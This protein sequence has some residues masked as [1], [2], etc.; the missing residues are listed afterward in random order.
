M[1]EPPNGDG[2]DGD[3]PDG[4]GQTAEEQAADNEPSTVLAKGHLHP[5]I[6][7]LRLI[8]ALRQ[9]A[10]PVILGIV[11]NPWFLVAALALFVAAARATSVAFA[12]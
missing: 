10:F 7:L 3:G 2:P 8:D 9:V 5:A 11:T 12:T 1:V 6:L 4:D